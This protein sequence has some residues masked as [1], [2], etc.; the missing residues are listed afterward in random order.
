[1]WSTS[2]PVHSFTCC[3]DFAW[4]ASCAI[5]NPSG[6]WYYPKYD[7]STCYERL[8]SEFDMYDPEN[9]EK[10]VNKNQC[11]ME[12]FSNNVWNCCEQGEGE[13]SMSGDTVYIPDWGKQTCAERDAGLVPKWESDWVSTSMEACCGQYFG[14]NMRCGLSQDLSYYFPDEETSE[15]SLKPLSESESWE[16][17]VYDSLYDCCSDQF[18]DSIESC[19]E[20]LSA[21]ECAPSGTTIWLPDWANRHCYEKVRIYN[22]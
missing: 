22:D 16:N 1:M 21:G 17:E 14:S 13:C 11:C 4:D 19:C 15:C 6:V 10:Y 9:Y 12:K 20:S 2:Y 5:K 8:S 3:L 18:P 7:E